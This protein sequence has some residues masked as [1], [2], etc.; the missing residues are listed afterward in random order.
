MQQHMAA[1]LYICVLE[2][3]LDDLRSRIRMCKAKKIF[4]KAQLRAK[5]DATNQPRDVVAE[6][7]SFPNPPEG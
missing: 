1:K 4:W 7:L 6:C 2:K 3:E 5:E